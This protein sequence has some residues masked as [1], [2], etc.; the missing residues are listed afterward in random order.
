MLLSSLAN[1]KDAQ[2]L[3]EH[4]TNALTFEVEHLVTEG[5]LTYLEAIMHIIAEQ[6]LETETVAKI[7]SPVI[8]DKLRIEAIDNNHFRGKKRSRGKLKLKPK[9]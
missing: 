6:Q 2:S 3:K 9:S 7:L 5:G 1:R 8:V 4:N